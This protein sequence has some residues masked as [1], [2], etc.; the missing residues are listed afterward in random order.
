MPEI[1]GAQLVG[2]F[3]PSDQR[4]RK[5]GFPAA[6]STSPA[7]VRDERRFDG[8]DER[9]FRVDQHDERGAES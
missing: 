1:E 3:V 7:T 9:V 8:A 4:S 5:V 6:T 2:T